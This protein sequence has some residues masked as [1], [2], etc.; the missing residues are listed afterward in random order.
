[1]DVNYP[2]RFPTAV[3]FGTKSHNRLGIRIDQ[4]IGWPKT[5][6]DT[7]DGVSTIRQPIADD[8]S[9][10][11]RREKELRK[12]LGVA[13][14]SKNDLAIVEETRLLGTCEWFKAR[15]LWVTGKPASGKSTLAGYIINSLQDSQEACS[16]FFF[17]HSDASKSTLTPCLRSL[18]YQMACADPGI[19]DALVAIMDDDD[20][21]LADHDDSERA[22][23]RKLFTDCILQKP[24]KRHFWIIDALD[25]CENAFD[26]FHSILGKWNTAVSLR[27]LVTSRDTKEL[28]MAFQDLRSQYTCEAIQSNDTA[29]DIKLFV[30]HYSPRIST[31]NED[32]RNELVRT[33]LKKSEGSFIW[34]RLVLNE[35]AEAN[36]EKEV[37][38]ILTNVPGKMEPLYARTLLL[39]SRAKR[40][41]SL[42]SA[43]LSWVTCASRPLSTEE[44]TAAL[45]MYLQEDITRLDASILAVCG[46]LVT[47]DRFNKVQLVHETVRDW[48]TRIAAWLRCVF[49]TSRAAQ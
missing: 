49:D 42:A 15:V 12:Y 46:Q 26:A 23:W 6:D 31:R 18:A 2:N 1:V 20:G 34:T 16:Y 29:E 44:L 40:G 21:R 28:R 19:H 25:E 30:R 37:A 48:R 36:S 13:E 39:M 45:N 47:V 9:Q 32:S 17:K 27:V 38:A 11:K 5:L 3:S 7:P 43:I 33:I 10:Y 4:S 35:L 24:F 22:V 8:Y 41:K 14:D